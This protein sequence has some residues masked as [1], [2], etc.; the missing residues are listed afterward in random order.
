MKTRTGTKTEKVNESCRETEEQRV[1]LRN[2]KSERGRDD[3]RDV[4][5]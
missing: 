4:E 1:I 2:T 5:V 3:D